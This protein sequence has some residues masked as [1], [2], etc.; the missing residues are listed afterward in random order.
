VSL[1]PRDR[2]LAVLRGDRPDKAPFT[3]YECMIPQCATERRLRNEGVCIIRTVPVVA[4]TT[5]HVNITTRTCT[6]KGKTL[7]RT[8][9]ETPYGTVYAIDEPA[10]FTVWH[11]K[12]LFGG[13]EDY[14]ALLFLIEDEQY[15]TNY[16]AF[17]A[18]QQADGGDSLLRAMIGSEPLQ[19][20]IS[21]YMGTEAF[22]LEWHDRQDEIIKLY[23]AIVSNRRRIYPL[24]AD[25]PALTFNYGGNVAP[26]IMGLDRF[27]EYYVPHYNE[28]AEVLHAKGKLIGC[29]FDAN[30]RAFAQAIAKTK[31]DYIEAFT[32]APDT[33]MTLA[34]G[35]ASWPDKTIW[36]NFPSSVHLDSLG[37]I[38]RTTESLLAQID[39]SKQ[40]I[41]G[42]TEDVPEDRWRDNLLAISQV[43]LKHTW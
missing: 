4:T 42:I 15:T 8:D 11:H 43:L 36:I 28:A 31:L 5:P 27:E 40:F 3:I 39:P 32:P 41:I 30:C 35:R 13:P 10:G 12:R 33:D 25:S 18:A 26:E 34:E 6:E 19:I 14:R 20:L 9:F 7:T 24:L 23:D 22:C 1:S 29:H 21:Y 17:E 37:D 38:A 16:D 2:V